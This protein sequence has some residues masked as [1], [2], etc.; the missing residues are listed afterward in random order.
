M[1]MGEQSYEKEKLE[2]RLKT[3]TPFWTGGVQG[4]NDCLRETGIAGS[5]RWWYE[6]IVRGLGGTACD[7]C[8]HLHEL[9]G[10]SLQYYK[11]ARRQGK[12]W[13]Q[14]LDAVGVCDACK[15]FGTTG[16][17]RQFQF[18]IRDETRLLW[19]PPPDAL[20]V[21]PPDRTRGW[22]MPPGRAGRVVLQ[23]FGNKEVL[24]QLASLF[25]FLEKWGTLGA[26][27]QLGYGVFQVENREA[28]K[29]WAAKW[30][31]KENGLPG[32]EDNCPDLRRFGFFR[33]RFRPER[34][35]WW[36]WL[37]ALERLLGRT[38]TARALKKAAEEGM[39]PVLPVLKNE[40][41]FN[42][43]KGPFRIERWLFG[44]S[45]GKDDRVRSKISAS[46][47]Y[48][49]GDEWEVRGWVWFPEQDKEKKLI[50][51]E[52]HQQIWEAVRDVDLWCAALKVQEG[53]LQTRPDVEL[54]RK[55]QPDE[56]LN[57]LEG[58]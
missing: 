36:S 14:A 9:S 37:P 24:G 49:N 34:Q 44:I 11:E 41:R 12:S 29:S 42:Y 43:W 51:G 25:L 47:A 55:W 26:K 6:A 45:R 39:V 56:V 23:F 31:E 30:T 8:K 17:K 50:P 4:I 35:D 48:R 58:R 7:P 33:F 38:D 21:R 20:N 53:E 22:F 15:I 54:W 10:K 28:V 46:W 2:I 16:W 52:Y 40:W 32:G 1:K 3:L 13:W 57:F 19:E 5:L 27:P 18:K